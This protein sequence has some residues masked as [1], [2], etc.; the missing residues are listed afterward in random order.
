MR[1]FEILIFLA[2][3]NVV[4]ISSCMGQDQWDPKDDVFIGGSDLG[5]PTNVL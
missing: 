4:F 1:V 2:L 5:K 3:F